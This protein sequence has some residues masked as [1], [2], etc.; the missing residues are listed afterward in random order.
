MMRW[1]GCGFV[2]SAF[3]KALINLHYFGI[4]H[5]FEDPLYY[6]CTLMV[7]FLNYG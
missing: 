6:F 3:L 5:C 4:K 7:F 2:V 1:I